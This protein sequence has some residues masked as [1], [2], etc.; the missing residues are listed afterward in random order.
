[1]KELMALTKIHL[2]STF[3]FSDMKYKMVKQK[4]DL[5]KPILFI[6]LI[7]SLIPA[8]MLYLALIDTM[9]IGLKMINQTNSMITLAF[10]AA[11]LM[12]LVFSI[13][14]AMSVYYF[15]TDIN[16]L[17]PLPIKPKNIILSKFIGMVITQYLYVLPFIIPVLVTFAI[18][19]GRGIVFIAYS[20]I[21]LILVPIAPLSIS[22]IL[23]MLLMKITNIKGKKD[24]IRTISMFGLLAIILGV[25]MFIS[26]GANNIPVGEEQQYLVQ[27]FQDNMNLVNMVGKAFPLSIIV[28][29]ALV[30]KSVS[31]II[32]FI[33]GVLISLIFLWATII[34]GEKIYLAGILGGQERTSGAKKLSSSD[35][36]VKLRKK[37]HPSIAVFILDLKLILR[38]PPYILNCVAMVILMPVILI[39]MPI[40]SGDMAV[41]GITKVYK[42]SYGIIN[43]VVI[44]FF[45][46]IAAT[47]PTASTTFSREGKNFWISRLAPIKPMDQ[48]KG[49]MLTSSVLQVVGIIFSIIGMSF[50]ISLRIDTIFISLFFGILGSLPIFLIGLI[51]DLFRPVL[52][53]DNP[54]KAVKQNMNVLFSMLIGIVY[55]VI[56]GLLVFFLW[57]IFNSFLLIYVILTVIFTAVT[58]LLLFV[59]NN[60][61]AE[62]ILDIE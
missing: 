18:N 10:S 49:R 62:K 5:W 7:G 45:I 56:L 32:Y 44:G 1:M 33:V 42:E 22:T 34:L 2:N 8:Y 38:T 17:L 58:I 52:N 12:I 48:I 50:L 41:E 28:T 4:K 37:S 25:Q 20:I 47:N 3:G 15:S 61:F 23:I 35:L 57:K 21:F 16:V 26:K 11:S 19:E 27:M 40:F 39:V 14:Q 54:Q 6:I 51:I 55:I 46:F 59:I 31:S 24:L 36:K 60:I 29:K 9:Y 53:W 30:I 13:I 43:L